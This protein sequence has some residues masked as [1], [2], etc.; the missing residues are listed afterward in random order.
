MTLYVYKAMEAS[1]RRVGGRMDAV[2]PADLETRLKRMG[3]D[4]IDA[5]RVRHGAIGGARVSR[6]ELINLCFHLEQLANAGVPLLEALADLR[7]S[8]ADR[9]LRD[10]LAAMVA[11]IEGGKTL[12]QAMADHPAAFDEVMVHLVRAG[13]VTGSLP[14]ALAGLAESLKWRDELAAQ[15]RRLLT[16]P[17][18]LLFVTLAMV[19]FVMIYV[20]PKMIAFVNNLGQDLPL[21]TQLLIGVSRFVAAHWPLLFG[22][23]LLAA[24]ALRLAVRVSPRARHAA[25]GAKLRLPLVGGIL[26]KIVLARFAATFA[27]MYGAGIS[28]LDSL[29]AGERIVG[30]AAIAAGL[31]RAGEMISEGASVTAAFER[32]GMFPPLVVRML[33]VGENSGA[34]DRALSNVGYF[35]HRDVRESVERVQTLIEP[36]MTVVIGI[37]M[38]WVM[39][40]VLGPIYDVIGRLN[41]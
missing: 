18:F 31:R 12:S 21:Q 5:D 40:S 34:L 14:Q 7:D 25:D 30:N 27:M 22:A 4:L 11:G 32:L 24:A 13:E 17:L 38:G 2:N 29:R 39:L 36:A 37:F 35:Y 41:V 8:V 1:G 23:P 28:V 6:R 16:Y 3:L 20:T 9:R 10:V 15:S 26:R 19:M 33:R